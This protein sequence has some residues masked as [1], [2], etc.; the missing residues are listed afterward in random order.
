MSLKSYIIFLF[1][2]RAFQ[3]FMLLVARLE[4]AYRT[5]INKYCL[6]ENHL[7]IKVIYRCIYQPLLSMNWHLFQEPGNN[8]PWWQPWQKHTVTFTDLDQGSEIIMF[9]SILTAFEPSSIFCVSQ[10]SNKNWLELKIEP[11]MANLN[12]WNTL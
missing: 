11:S 12:R 1:K 10:G 7:T 8:Q 6:T 2:N 4:E 3:F 9:E 5:L